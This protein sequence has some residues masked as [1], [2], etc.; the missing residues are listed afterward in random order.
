MKTVLLLGGCIFLSV[1]QLHAQPA[2]QSV[3]NS[4]GHSYKGTFYQVDWSIGELALVNEM[5]GGK[6]EW[7]IT[8]GF[9]QST[10]ST[11][12]NKESRFSDEEIR[13]LPNV[14]EDKVDVNL[15]TRQQGKVLLQVMDV[16]GRVV[17]RRSLTSYGTGHMERLSLRPL[18]SGTYFLKIDLDPAPGSVKKTGSYKIVKL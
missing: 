16:N 7:I 5:K 2:T 17:F 10:E 15:L 6:G 12:I 9:L 4:T 18:A 13:V 11:V 3:V 14:T 1:S 8:N